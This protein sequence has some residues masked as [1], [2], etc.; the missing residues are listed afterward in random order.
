MSNLQVP[1]SGQCREGM[2]LPSGR[3]KRQEGPRLLRVFLGLSLCLPSEKMCVQPR[4]VIFSPGSTPFLWPPPRTLRWHSGWVR[5]ERLGNCALSCLAD[6]P[7]IQ[8]RHHPEHRQ[9]RGHRAGHPRALLRSR[10]DELS[11]GPLPGREPEHGSE[12]V[13]QHV[14]GDLCLPVRRATLGGRKSPP[15]PA[16]SRVASSGPSGVRA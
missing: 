3:P 14:C 9:G 10:Q 15:H 4:K 13:P 8:P 5:A 1:P 6:G 12:G 2:C 16:P 7:P 11:W